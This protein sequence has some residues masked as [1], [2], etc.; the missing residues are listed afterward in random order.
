[1]TEIPPPAWS[2]TP[3]PASSLDSALELFP[4][5]R[6]LISYFKESERDL[7]RWF[8]SAG[9]L[10]QYADSVR[11][12]LLKST[13]RFDPAGH[14]RLYEL[15]HAAAEALGIGVPITIYQA[16]SSSELN[17]ALAF[18][19]GEVHI[20]FQGGVTK[21]LSEEELKAVLAH[22]LT[23][24]LLWD[25]FD[26]ELLVAQQLLAAI[27]AHRDASSCHVESARLFALYVEIHADRGSLVV[28][29]DPMAAIRSLIKVQTGLPDIHAE[30]YLRQ[31]DE[32]F[33]RER[34]ATQQ[35][36]HPES[37]IRARALRE[38]AQRGRDAFPEIAHMIEGRPVI[39]CLDLVAQARLANTT[40][41]FL[42]AF[43]APC[44]F[45]TD[46]VMAHARKFFPDFEA[47]GSFDAALESAIAAHDPSVRKYFAYV[48]LD[49]AVA[50]PQLE[51]VPIAAIIDA[52]LRCGFGELMLELIAKELA[53]PKKR[54]TKIEKERDA[55]L[56][57]AA[58]ETGA[59]A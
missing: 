12:E 50:D 18:V 10:V 55:I 59:G 32:I 46:G 3:P 58:R 53:L 39:D 26:R 57:A 15:A 2:A 25:R 48:L 33:S 36:T 41:Q 52:A 1:M 47:G 23:H 24:Y 45:R 28:M 22:E 42:A 38:W 27:A 17:A 54:L 8:A 43:L 30:S 13:Y 11:L 20:V 35:L 14:A 56:A 21:L 29:Q 44:W 7:W 40:R 6:E 34:V 4:Y 37:F 19:P 5:Q 16:T 49:F 31:A 9:Y 51:D